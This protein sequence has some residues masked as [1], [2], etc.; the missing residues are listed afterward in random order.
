[1]GQC[2]KSMVIKVATEQNV[3][4]FAAATPTAN[5]AGSVSYL[6]LEA[7]LFNTAT[8]FADLTAAEKSAYNLKMGLWTDVF[9]RDPTKIEGDVDQFRLGQ[10]YGDQPLAKTACVYRRCSMVLV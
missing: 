10:M 1:M 6:M 4:D 7:P 2:G 9:V 8:S 5:S 3:P